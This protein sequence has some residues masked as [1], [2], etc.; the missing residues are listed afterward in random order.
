MQKT[1]IYQVTSRRFWILIRL[2][3]SNTRDL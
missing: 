2:I 3:L 1:F